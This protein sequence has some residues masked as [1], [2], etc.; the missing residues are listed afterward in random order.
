MGD[1]N[2]NAIYHTAVLLFDLSGDAELCYP[3]MRCC[4]AHGVKGAVDW[5]AS[6]MRRHLERTIWISIDE[7]RQ[8]CIF[9]LEH[10][11][12]DIAVTCFRRCPCG[13][14]DDLKW[15]ADGDLAHDCPHRSLPQR[16]KV[17]GDRCHSDKPYEMC[18]IY[19]QER[20]GP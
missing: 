4:A 3:A 12:E 2:Y 19:E 1:K 16:C 11:Y 7:L 5:M 13:A 18:D 9:A 8:I 10:G 20:Y 17:T 6:E 15:V 14:L